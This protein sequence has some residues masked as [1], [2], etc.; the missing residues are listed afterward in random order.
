MNA[1]GKLKARRKSIN[2]SQTMKFVPLSLVTFFLS[3][4]ATMTNRKMQP[5]DSIS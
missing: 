5:Y 1:E 4:L 2:K 3:F